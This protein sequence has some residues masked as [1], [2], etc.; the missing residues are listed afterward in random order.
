[1]TLP[2]ALRF[3]RPGF[4][5]LHLLLIP[6]VFGGGVALGIFHATGHG[7]DPHAGHAAPADPHAGHAA[8]PPPTDAGDNPLRAEMVALQAAY[9]VLNRAVVLGDPAGVSAAF[10]A[11]HLRKEATSAALAAGT[12]KPPRNADRLDD[13]VARDEAFHALLGRTV[14]AA[15]AGDVATLRAMVPELQAACVSCHET[16]RAAP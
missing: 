7:A 11:V 6:T 16:F 2:P 15:D 14:T 5:A 4:W 1:M 12:V 10:H 13:F 8:A 9:D 3:P